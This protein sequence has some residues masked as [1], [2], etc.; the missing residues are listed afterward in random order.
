MFNK[1]TFIKG[2]VLSKNFF[3]SSSLSTFEQ[4][5]CKPLKFHLFLKLGLYVKI[6]S[7][8][9]KINKKKLQKCWHS[10]WRAS[11]SY[12]EIMSWLSTLIIKSHFDNFLLI[13]VTLLYVFIGEH[14]NFT[15][16]LSHASLCLIDLSSGSTTKFF[17]PLF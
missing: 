11:R 7:C 6:T 10:F 15:W 3:F 5:S 16:K 4:K 1:L 9:N 2:N 13:S 8:D 14:G 17:K 12:D